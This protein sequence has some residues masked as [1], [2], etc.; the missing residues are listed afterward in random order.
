MKNLRLFETQSAYTAAESNLVLPNVSLI[1]ELNSVA[2]KPYVDLYA[3]H[4]YVEIAGIKWATMNIGANN[5]TDSGLYFEWGNTQGYAT[6]QIG[7]E[8]GKKAFDDEWNDYKYANITYDPDDW[9]IIEMTKYNETDELITLDISDDAAHTAWGG[10]W[11][12][13]T[14]TEFQ[15]L[16][17]AV[18]TEWTNDYNSSGI[19][20]M[21]CT[22]K[23]DN[24][25]VLFFP[26]AGN[27]YNGNTGYLNQHG[28]YWSSSLNSPSSVQ[29][30]HT[31]WF[32][33]MQNN[34][35]CNW[36]STLKRCYGIPIRPVAD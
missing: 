19:A 3:G 8:E 22:D 12:M 21:I 18:N 20:G 1:T 15:A 2:Y 31:L 14:K 28:Y 23:T 9:P 16:V 11:R 30:G 26:A 29:H 17:N 36:D 5:I 13:P 33:L 32:R 10:N 24:S 34:L 7:K 25:K 6:N 35:N 27:K 4:D